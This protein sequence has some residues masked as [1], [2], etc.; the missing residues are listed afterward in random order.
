VI[1]FKSIKPA[2]LKDKDMRLTV[3]NAMRKTGTKIKKDFEKTTKTWDKKPKFEVVV[4]LT[5]PGPVVLVD[6]DDQVYLWVSKGTKGPYPIPKAGPG[7]LAFRPGYH[8]KTVPNVLGS[9]A[10]GAYGDKIIRNMQV[11]HPGIKPR[12]FDKM[13][14]KIWNKRFK[15]E[16][17]AVMRD[18]VKASGHAI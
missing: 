17:E 6:T 15:R 10:G 7:L 8:P 18:V 16:M 13:V 5:G 14:Q 9:R 2:R 4:S 11:M 3:L 1:V 12:N